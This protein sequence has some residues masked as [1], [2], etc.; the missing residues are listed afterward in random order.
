MYGGRYYSFRAELGEGGERRN[1]GGVRCDRQ[2]TGTNAGR[3]VGGGERRMGR[4]E[5]DVRKS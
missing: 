2:H 1:D 5:R 3:T 4:E